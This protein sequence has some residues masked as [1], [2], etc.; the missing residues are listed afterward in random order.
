M[1]LRIDMNYIVDPGDISPLKITSN[2]KAWFI[3]SLNEMLL[4]C[5]FKG[6][7]M[8]SMKFVIFFFSDACGYGS[9][10]QADV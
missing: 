7:K 1:V 10:M 4:Y 5:S 6:H 3:V 2:L 9:N 8:L